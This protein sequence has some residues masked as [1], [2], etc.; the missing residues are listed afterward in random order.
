MP[1]SGGG[2]GGGLQVATRTLTNAEIKALPTTLYEIVPAPGVGKVIYSPALA[3]AGGFAAAR[4]GAVDYTHI[5][6]NALFCLRLSDAAGVGSSIARWFGLGT[7]F[8]P[9]L[10]GTWSGSWSACATPVD[11]QNGVGLSAENPDD[12]E[13]MPLRFNIAN[14]LVGS[15]GDF[16]GGAAGQTLVVTVLYAI[17]TL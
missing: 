4:H 13:N 7:N 2:S 12:V 17:I 5:D 9:D 10:L 1:Y 8:I 3:Q 16:T 11:Q 15:I 6:P 14:P